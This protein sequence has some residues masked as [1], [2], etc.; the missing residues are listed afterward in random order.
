MRQ[1]VGHSSVGSGGSRAARDRRRRRS[2]RVAHSEKEVK[3]LEHHQR[4]VR[5]HVGA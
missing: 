4:P 1:R 2:L 3:E 5:R